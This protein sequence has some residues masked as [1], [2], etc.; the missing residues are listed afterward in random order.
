VAIFAK[1]WHWWSLAHIGTVVTAAPNPSANTLSR[2]LR[3][4]RLCLAWVHSSRGETNSIVLSVV[5]F[6]LFYFRAALPLHPFCP[7]CVNCQQGP[8]LSHFPALS[9]VTSVATPSL[10]RPC[11]ACAGPAPLSPRPCFFDAI[12]VSTP[13]PPPQPPQYAHLLA[14]AFDIHPSHWTCPLLPS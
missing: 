7:A 8:S 12:V 14:I 13:P 2:G 4:C 9:P 10:H 5:C 11:L 3:Q 6:C 1:P